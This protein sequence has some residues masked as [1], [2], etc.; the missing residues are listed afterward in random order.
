MMLQAGGTGLLIG[1]RAEPI[2][3]FAICMRPVKIRMKEQFPHGETSSYIQDIK[4]ND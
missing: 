4:F 2:T 3:Y 1:I